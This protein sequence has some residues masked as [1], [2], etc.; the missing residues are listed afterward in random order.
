MNRHCRPN[1][2]KC[3][4]IIVILPGQ[5]IRIHL[6]SSYSSHRTLNVPI[7]NLRPSS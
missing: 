1:N 4:R 2:G 3:F 6:R 7:P 5:C